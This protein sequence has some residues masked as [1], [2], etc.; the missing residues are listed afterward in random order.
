MTNEHMT[1]EEVEEYLK[2]LILREKLEKQIV[3]EQVRIMKDCLR[4]GQ[5][6]D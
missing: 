6:W 2:A 5:Q 3:E 4:I 1:K